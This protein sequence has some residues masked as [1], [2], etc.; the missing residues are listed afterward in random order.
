[1]QIINHY[2]I[3]GMKM[4]RSLNPSLNKYKMIEKGNVLRYIS[5]DLDEDEQFFQTES[6]LNNLLEL[7]K[8][9]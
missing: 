8:Y 5:K 1:M 4:D 7:K 3:K 2:Q 6:H 9:Y